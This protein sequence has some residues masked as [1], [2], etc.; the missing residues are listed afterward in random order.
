MSEKKSV[1]H[2]ISNLAF[3]GVQH[4]LAKSLSIFDREQFNHLV[5]CVTDGGVYE[6]ELKEIGIPYWI[7]NRRFRFDPTIIHQMALLMREQEIDVVHTLNFTANAWGRVAAKIAG[8]P[9]IIAHER[10]TGWTENAMMRL[11]DRRLYP[12]TD[13]LLA[14]SQASKTILMNRIG[15]PEDRILVLYNGLPE[16][17]STMEPKISLREQCGISTK[18]HLIG[19]VGRLDTPKGHVFLLDAIPLVWREMPD[20]HFVII[21]GGPLDEHLRNLATENDLLEGK[22]LHFTGFLSQAAQYMREMDIIVH[23]SVREPLGNVLIEAGWAGKAVVGSYV[24]GCGEVVEDGKTGILIPGS[25]P[26]M[27]TKGYRA[28]PLPSLVVDGKT[29]AL[30]SPLG[31]SPY[32]MANAILPLLR[33]PQQ[34]IAMGRAARERIQSKFTIERYVNQLEEIYRGNTPQYAHRQHF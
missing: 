22:R 29:Q 23:P 16:V 6:H 12:F 11:V 4:L 14:N 19:T 13:V 7:M 30:R 26:V 18:T 10:G 8:V 33:N 32:A 2:V 15:L 25:E 17:I 5:C 20:T 34:C 28:S 31:P 1:L 24:D 3:G 21:G 27:T 9:R